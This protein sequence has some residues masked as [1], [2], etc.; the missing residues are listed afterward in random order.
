MDDFSK[1]KIIF[2]EITKFI[3]FH[4]DTEHFVT[5]N[6]CFII[7]GQHIEFLTAF[8]NSSLFKYCFI[9]NFPELL[10]GTRELRK[11]FL[12]KI[13]I[14]Q[15]EDNIND[16]FASNISNIHLLKINNRNSEKSE[17]DIDNLIFD[18]YGLTEEERKEIGFIKIL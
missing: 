12:E 14:I 16:L 11:I 8:L 7:T 9:D 15:I 5:N 2:P 6:K 1:H 3:N 13:P 4:Y 17:I 18:L 10:G